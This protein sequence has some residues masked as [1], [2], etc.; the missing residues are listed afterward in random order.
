MLDKIST[1]TALFLFFPGNLIVSFFK[2]Y[3]I[4]N[5]HNQLTDS[6][7]ISLSIFIF[8][9]LVFS[10]GLLWRKLIKASDRNKIIYTLLLFIFILA[11]V[12]TTILFG[13]FSPF[14]LV[15]IVTL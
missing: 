13:I 15:S 5:F 12:S 11:C 10:T 7:E 1:K 9:F 8:A 14:G 2:T 3:I 6:L 4:I